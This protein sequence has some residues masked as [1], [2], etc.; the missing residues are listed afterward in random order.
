VVDGRSGYQP[1][2]LGTP[3]GDVDLHHHVLHCKGIPC[4]RCVVVP[5]VGR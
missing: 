2:Y 3:N 1:A 4:S 5:V